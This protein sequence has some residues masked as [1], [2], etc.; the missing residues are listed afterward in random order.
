MKRGYFF[1][2]FLILVA[3]VALRSGSH[4]DTSERT[5]T[6]VR[7]TAY[8]M[9][10]TRNTSLALGD[11]T[12]V[13]AYFEFPSKHTTEEYTK[14]MQNMLSLQDPMVIF[15][16]PDKKDLM[17]RMRNHALNRTLVIMMNLE[18]TAVVRTYGMDFWTSQH[19][20]DPWHAIHPDPR[21]YVVWNEKI[22]F[23]H[24]SI[25]LNPFASSHFAWMDIGFLRHNRYNGRRLITDA[26]PFADDRV[27]TLDMTAMSANFFY[28][29][30][31][32]N[33]NR[34]CGN[35]FGGTTAAM[36]MYHS[37]YQ[38]TLAMDI[39]MSRF[40][41]VDQI[42]MW[43]T[44]QRIPDLCNIVKVSPR[45]GEM[46]RTCYRVQNQLHRVVNWSFIT[47]D[48]D[49]QD[50]WFYMVPFLLDKLWIH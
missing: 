50:P 48:P 1:V 33:E 34:L 19:R 40:V 7:G 13:T 43:R 23:V 45:C 42:E 36:E 35:F 24:K 41:G 17:Y 14:W 38:K 28:D 30:F 10:P 20:Q 44:C 16:T 8:D 4:L 2:L 29:R 26:T 37:E 5:D 12:I 21:I 15:T 11:A 25:A 27:L 3:W 46:W 9:N 49:D 31:T 6:H 32:E 39:A 18:E 47:Q 22:S